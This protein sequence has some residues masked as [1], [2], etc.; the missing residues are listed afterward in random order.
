MS[1]RWAILQRDGF[2]CRACG[3]RGLLE[4][5][6]RTPLHLGGTDAAANLQLLCVRCHVRKSESDGTLPAPVEGS[7]EWRKLV[8]ERLAK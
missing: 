1:T 6:H 4:V 8:R 7:E 2:K 3:R 5:D